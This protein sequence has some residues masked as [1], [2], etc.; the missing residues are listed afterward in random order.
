MYDPLWHLRTTDHGPDLA[1]VPPGSHISI[2]VYRIDATVSAW[3]R[4]PR[5]TGASPVPGRSPIP[6]AP[7][8]SRVR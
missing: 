4:R 2:A 8:R 1:P 6:R 3:S 5:C 7:V